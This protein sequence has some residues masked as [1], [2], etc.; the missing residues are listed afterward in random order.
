MY[1]GGKILTF[2]SSSRIKPTSTRHH[3]S[4][5]MLHGTAGNNPLTLRLPNKRPRFE[6]DLF[7]NSIYSF[8]P[9]PSRRK[10]N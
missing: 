5:W 7:I 3:G 9:I 6:R 1:I 8:R 2:T 4:I 10:P